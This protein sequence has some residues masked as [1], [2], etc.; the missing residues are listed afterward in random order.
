MNVKDRTIYCR[1]NLDILNGINSHCIDLI[2]LDPPFNKKKEFTAP[3]GSSAEGSSFEDIFRKKD[4]KEEWLVTIETDFRDLAEFL[5]SLKNDQNQYNFCYLAYM[6]IRLIECQRILKNTGSIYLHCDPT[7]SHYLKIVMDYVFGEKN[8]RNEVIWKRATT[9]NLGVKQ[10]PV[11]HDVILFYSK[12]SKYT[13]WPVYIPWTDEQI[14]EKYTEMDQL[15]R[16][17]KS[18]LTG[19]STSYSHSGKEWR[20]IKPAEGRNWS[21]PESWPKQIKKPNN[22]SELITQE[23]LDYIDKVG[24]IHWSKKKNGKPRFKKY[25]STSKGKKVEDLMT[26]IPNVQAHS[27]QKTGYPTQKP[28]ALLE[29]LIQASS[30]KGDIVLDPFCGCATACLA[31]EKLNRRWVGIDKSIEAFE[32]IKKRLPKEVEKYANEK[33]HFSTS[34]PKRTDK[35][36]DEKDKRF[37][38][39]I[40]HPLHTS[41][42]KV[43]IAKDW[44][45]RL[46]QY[47][48]SDPHRQYQCEFQLETPHFKDIEKYIH[49]KFRYNHEWVK[50]K[51]KHIINEMK[52]YQYDK[53]N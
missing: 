44:K 49:N 28:L 27:K 52:A 47:Q 35:G 45:K 32:F 9:K 6:S 1:D 5:H 42:Y 53:T 31:A 4:I 38:Y 8:F 20:G 39:I 37:V 33:V 26:D 15:G 29:R 2:Y 3:I 13:F 40:S 7:M 34:P 24:L 12:N 36:I 25:A 21:I 46:N 50:G 18:D 16:Y 48:T 10:Y 11:N 19:G 22:W 51:L 14:K 30:N 41:L 23:K 43:G 17:S